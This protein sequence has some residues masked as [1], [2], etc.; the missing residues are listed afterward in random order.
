MISRAYPTEDVNDVAGVARYA[1]SLQILHW[2]LA[3]LVSGQLGLILILRQLQ[4]VEFAQM[5]LNLHRACGT[6][7]WL[8]VILR[9]MVGL[10][11]RPPK[12]AAGRPVWRTA[13][14]RGVRATLLALLLAQPILGVLSSWA[15]GDDVMVMGL[16][17]LPQ[18]VMFTADQERVLTL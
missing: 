1:P 2:T 3:L 7:V 8:L 9:L 16:V 4:S 5:V 12:P 15:R 18:M 13:L 10:R 6:D 14:T 11:V 17:K